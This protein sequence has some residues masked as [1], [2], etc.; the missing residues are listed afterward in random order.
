LGAKQ[1]TVEVAR[2][3]L[4]PV[5]IGDEDVEHSVSNKGTGLLDRCGRC[6]AGDRQR[7]IQ[8]LSRHN[9]EHATSPW[10]SMLAQDVIRDPITNLFWWV[11]RYQ[12][13]VGQSFVI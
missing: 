11:G 8:S 10:L 12:I 6:L 1:E 7:P 2:G 5:R 13:R 4:P 3:M 9:E